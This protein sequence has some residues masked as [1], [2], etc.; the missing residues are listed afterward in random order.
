MK[1]NISINLDIDDNDIINIIKKS[2]SNNSTIVDTKDNPNDRYDPNHTLIATFNSIKD[3]DTFCNTY[4]HYNNYNGI[5]LGQR[6]QINDGKYNATW[7]IAGFDVE[8]EQV[9]FDGTDYDNGYGIMLIPENGI[10]KCQWDNKNLLGN[11]QGFA[12][13]YINTIVLRNIGK[14]LE[15]V[16]GNHLIKRDVQ[17]NN[18][19][20]YPENNKCAWTAEYCTLPTIKQ[21]TDD[22]L[23]YSNIDNGEAN[24]K[25]PLF[26]HMKYWC[27]NGFWV[28]NIW[29]KLCGFYRAFGV[30]YKGEI[31]NDRLDKYV[32]VRPLIYIR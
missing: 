8:H 23:Y 18:G 16:L 12:K 1:I 11:F 20:E 28:R 13:S 9:S 32:Q 27:K 21:L 3:V 15:S 7:Y 14:I 5:K 4:N 31:A 17:L 24:Y 22:Y 6:I 19:T 26:N 25:L 29:G 10:E 2:I 30:N